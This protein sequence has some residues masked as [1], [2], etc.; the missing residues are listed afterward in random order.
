MEERKCILKTINNILKVINN[1]WQLNI[2]RAIFFINLN[3]G[4]YGLF[5]KAK[6]INYTF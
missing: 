2:K 6:Y 3:L 5:T 1:K 4:T